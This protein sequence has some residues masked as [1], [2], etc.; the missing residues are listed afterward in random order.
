MLMKVKV[1]NEIITEI[2]SDDSSLLHIPADAVDIDETVMYGGGPEGIEQI[3]VDSSNTHF[4]VC[5]GCLVHVDT[6]TLVIAPNNSSVPTDGSIKII[7][8]GAFGNN[9]TIQELELP[10]GVELLDVGCF[11]CSS[12]QKLTL[13][14]SVLIVRGNAFGICA[15]LSEIIVLGKNT[16]FEISAF[17]KKLNNGEPMPKVFWEYINP[18]LTIK[19]APGSAVES[20]AK[21]NE[22]AYQEIPIWSFE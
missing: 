17:A 21:A 19:A 11:S 2:E 10:D 20:C 9:S 3:T 7:G 1:E 18:N 22:I 16:E 13:P 12:I 15:N 4:K 14:K 8:A 6:G 5:N